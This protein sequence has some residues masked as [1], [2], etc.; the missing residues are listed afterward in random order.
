MSVLWS[1]LNHEQRIDA[2]FAG[3]PVNTLPVR[4]LRL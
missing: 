2:Y 3:Q 4:C 1:S